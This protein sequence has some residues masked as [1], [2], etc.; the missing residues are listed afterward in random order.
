[1]N[2][3]T[4]GPILTI[5]RGRTDRHLRGVLSISRGETAFYIYKRYVT[6]CR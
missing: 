4:K 2:S 5:F 6:M 1:M 3:C